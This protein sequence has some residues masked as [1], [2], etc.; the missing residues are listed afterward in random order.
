MLTSFVLLTEI[1]TTTVTSTSPRTQITSVA[2]IADITES[3]VSSTS[4][5]VRS[6]TEL[7]SGNTVVTNIESTTNDAQQAT[8][9]GTDST[10]DSNVTTERIST[11]AS[12][13][14]D[15]ILFP[16]IERISQFEPHIYEAAGSVIIG[17][18]GILF[19]GAIFGVIFFLDF[20]TI[21][22]HLKML[23]KNL[24]FDDEQFSEIT[25]C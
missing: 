11:T 10:T 2:D 9:A 12:N 3:T 13:Y 7:H 5:D 6:T 14:S 23:K 22:K 25:D 1:E 24:G 18:M 4:Y 21:G 20:V 8:A 15:I 16:F 19:I 17:V